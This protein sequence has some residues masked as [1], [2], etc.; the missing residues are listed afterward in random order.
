MISVPVVPDGYIILSPLEPNLDIVIM[1]QQ[2]QEVV[3]DNL[4]FAFGDVVDVAYVVTDSEDALP[5][6]HWMRPNNL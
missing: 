5:P 4:T 3:Q 6:S 2:I 1:S